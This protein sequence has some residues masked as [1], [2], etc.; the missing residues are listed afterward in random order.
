[1]PGGVIE[2]AANLVSAR[3]AL[4]SDAFVPVTLM[5]AEGDEEEVRLEPYICGDLQSGYWDCRSGYY[6]LRNAQNARV[7]EGRVRAL[8]ARISS[9]SLGDS[10]TGYVYFLGPERNASL[11]TIATWAEVWRALKSGIYVGTGSGPF[12]PAVGLGMGLPY[13][14][15]A[16]IPHDGIVQAAPGV[17]VNLRYVQ[18]TGD[19]LRY[20]FRL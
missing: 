16:V 15:G 20:A 2:V 3:F 14:T 1:M 11:A 7:V 10:T 5:T 13:D 6:S 19:T 9:V 17:I 12:E 18:P 4:A 8:N